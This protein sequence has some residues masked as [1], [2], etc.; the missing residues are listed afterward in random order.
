M[1]TQ[2]CS[3]ASGSARLLDAQNI[4]IQLTHRSEKPML[5]A[6]PLMQHTLERWTTLRTAK[7]P[8]ADCMT[9][10]RANTARKG[11]GRAQTLRGK[12]LRALRTHRHRI[13]TATFEIIR[14]P[15]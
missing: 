3:V 6:G 8:T 12:T 7:T 5:R 11:D 10:R 14:S 1:H 9:S 13:A 2:T 4:S 15:I